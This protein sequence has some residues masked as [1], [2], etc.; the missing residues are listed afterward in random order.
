[1]PEQRIVTCA[2]CRQPWPGDVDRFGQHDCPGFGRLACCGKQV[3]MASGADA[4]G[5]KCEGYFHVAVYP[6]KN[7]ETVFS[8]IVFDD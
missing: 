4:V 5:H 8:R 7:P 1:M 2:V 6:P 3:V